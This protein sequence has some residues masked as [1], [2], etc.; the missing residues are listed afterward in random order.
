MKNAKGKLR[1]LICG[2]GSI[3]KKHARILRKSYK[4]EL[5]ALRIKDKG[6]DLGL[7]EISSW[8][9][10][11]EWMPDVVFVTNPTKYHIQTAKKVAQLGAAI[12]LE[13]PIGHSM[14]GVA[15][16]ERICLKKKS[17]CYVAYPLRFLPVIQKTKELL[18]NKKILHTRAVC[19]SYLPSWRPGTDYRKNYSS[20]YQEG[21]GVVLDLSHEFDLMTYL[22]GPVKSIMGV[23][24]RAS[25]I[26]VDAEDFADCLIRFENG[27]LANVHLNFMSQKAER[28]VHVDFKGGYVKS[29]LIANT[30]IFCNGTKRKILR[31]PCKRDNYLLKQ[32]NYFLNHLNNPKLMNNLSE[33]KDLFAKIISFREK[34]I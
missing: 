16:L 2:L 32:T 17:I 5:M 9:E 4:H 12:F 22:I 13:K 34:S 24:G 1:I 26:T 19:S 15:E 3:G 7:P 30:I 23:K 20:R 21:G 33:A 29:D 14:A 11:K 25:N 8:K 28:Y 10:A 6:N 27:S 31:L 18:K